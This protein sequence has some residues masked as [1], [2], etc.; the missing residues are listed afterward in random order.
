MKKIIK[1]CFCLVILLHG[2]DN[3]KREDPNQRKSKN[4]QIIKGV[5]TCLIW[6]EDD[7]G[8]KTYFLVNGEIN[9]PAKFYDADT[10]LMSEA[11][12]VDGLYSGNFK[13]YHKNQNIKLSG[14]YDQDKRIGKWFQYD[15]NGSLEMT[16]TFNSDGIMDGEVVE[17][18]DLGQVE[19]RYYSYRDTTQGAM[20]IFSDSKLAAYI[21]YSKFGKKMFE[22]HISEAGDTVAVIKWNN[23]EA[24]ILKGG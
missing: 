19:K 11:N 6:E 10:N 5:E 18:D 21:E 9:G 1:S 14:K 23:D 22:Y 20:E 4:C 24:K 13:S 7:K 2:C 8:Y 12:Y 15:F 17:Y 3:A 16:Y